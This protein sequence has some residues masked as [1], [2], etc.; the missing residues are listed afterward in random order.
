MLGTRAGA[1]H[2]ENDVGH[3]PARAQE[4]TYA[5]QICARVAAN[6]PAGGGLRGTATVHFGLTTSGGLAFA[7]V[8]RTSGVAMLDQLAVSAVRQ[9]APFPPPPAGATTAQLRFSIPFY[10]Q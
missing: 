3:R 8:S 4:D 10:F 2:G 9:S 1:A 6:K 5:A 7:S